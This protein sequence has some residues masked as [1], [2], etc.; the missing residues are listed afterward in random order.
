MDNKLEGSIPAE[1]GNLKHL[2]ELVL[3]SNALTGN[4]PYELNYL[5]ELSTIMVS[6]NNLNQDIASISILNKDEESLKVKLQFNTATSVA[7]DED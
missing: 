4:I 2:E 6:G 7:G 1:L 5:S 3:S